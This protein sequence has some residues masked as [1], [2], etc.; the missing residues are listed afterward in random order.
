MEWSGVEWSVL[1]TG[2]TNIK[3]VSSLLLNCTQVYCTELMI[4]LVCRR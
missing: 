4:F 3:N 1:N 2:M